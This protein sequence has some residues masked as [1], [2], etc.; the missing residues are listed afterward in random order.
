[1]IRIALAVFLV[2]LLIVVAISLQGDP[3]AASLTWLGW[4]VDTT[5]AAAVLI[6]G[7]LA[8]LATIF[9][10]VLLWLVDA[11]SRAG[12]QRAEARRRQGVEALTRGYLEAAAGN[13][14]EARRLAQRASDLAQE[15]PQLVRLLAA[16]AAEASGDRAAAE[17]A[18]RAMLGFP[19][20]RLAAYRGLTQT[21][22]AAGDGPEALKCAEAAY[23]LPHTA[24]WAWRA[25][26][27]AKLDAADWS[28]ALALVQGAQDRK[29][30]SPLVA[31]R[32]R[33]AL[34]S[35]TAAD[36]DAKGAAGEALEPAQAAAK[37]RP[38]F[39]PASI[40]TARLQARE[41]RTARAALALE[42]AWAARPHPAVWLAWRDLRTDE[43]P[44]E[45][46]ARLAQLASAQPNAREARILMVEQAL[47][48]GDPD[49]ARRGAEALENEAVTQRIAGLMAR[50][51]NASG[52]RDEARAWITRGAAAPEEAEWSDID[53]AGR[54]FAYGA[55]DWARLIVAYAETGELLHP[56]HERGEAGISDLPE[57]PAAYAD[58]A[59]FVSAAESGAPFPPIV[60]DGDFGEALQP[61]DGDDAPPARSGLMGRK[62]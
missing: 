4:R 60:D 34:Q 16:Q 54:A 2:S 20:M 32:A 9:W 45:R 30:V 5:A 59:A 15:T 25:L 33:A 36:L 3:G 12:R 42:A 1:M 35:V 13:G 18:Y 58:S 50:V 37:A 49:A 21:A 10:R 41:G 8:L 53:P 7:F 23:N 11:P 43:T 55:A 22:L 56:R 46:A 51:A 47:I 19:D 61:A 62:R 17:G 40:L 38:D 24:P 52:E 28:G 27:K 39:T 26:L 14:A 57:I 48:G 44:K 6:I 29:I 31:G